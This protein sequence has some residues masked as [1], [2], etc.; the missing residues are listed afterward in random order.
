MNKNESLAPAQNGLMPAV[1]DGKVDARSLHEALEIKTPFTIWIDRRVNEFGF[2]DKIDHNKIVSPSGR[3]DYTLTIDTAKELA[4]VERNEKGRQIR[5]YFIECE[6][7]LRENHAAPLLQT[8][9]LAKLQTINAGLI[10]VTAENQARLGELEKVSAPGDDWMAVADYGKQWGVTL[11]NGR[12]A[13]LSV[14]CLAESSVQRRPVGE[15]RSLTKRRRRTFA[16]SVLEAVIPPILERWE[17]QGK[18]TETE[19]EAAHA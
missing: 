4:M 10:E 6:K 5:R 18:I 19:K 2:E 7:A 13:F 16:P 14:R 17:K 11:S 9:T 8:D 1:T 15:D 3:I 12:L